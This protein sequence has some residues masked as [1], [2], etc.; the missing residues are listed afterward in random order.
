M[1]EVNDGTKFCS[2]CRCTSYCS[3]EC[4]ASHWKTHHKKVCQPDAI[5]VALKAGN[6]LPENYRPYSADELKPANFWVI[7]PGTAKRVPTDDRDALCQLLESVDAE[8]SLDGDLV[9]VSDAV[10]SAM[11]WRNVANSFASGYGVEDSYALRVCYDRNFASRKDLDPNFAASPLY[12]SQ[13]PLRGRFV[14]YKVKSVVPH[15]ADGSAD[16]TAAVAATGSMAAACEGDLGARTGPVP[17]PKTEIVDM[18]VWRRYCGRQ[19]C[20]SS[21]IHREN[22]RRREMQAILEKTKFETVML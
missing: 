12:S 17:F 10:A 9:S 20:T 4:Q 2:K 22:M 21:R 6:L 19:G 18:C 14:V 1:C 5:V 7:L 15:D 3:R 13:S 11:G 16:G 8:F